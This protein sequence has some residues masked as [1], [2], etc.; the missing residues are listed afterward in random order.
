MEALLEIW[1]LGV[2]QL[3]KLPHLAGEQSKLTALL[4]KK[5]LQLYAAGACLI[6]SSMVHA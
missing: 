6:N 3:P 2:A 5:H 1:D 4:C